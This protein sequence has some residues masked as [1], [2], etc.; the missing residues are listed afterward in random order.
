MQEL[1]LSICVVL[2]ESVEVTQRFHRALMASLEGFSE[3]EVLYYDNSPSDTLKHWFA[4]RLQPAGSYWHDPRNLG[5]SYGNNE[6]ILRARHERILLLNPDVFGLTPA[7]W[8]AIA[9]RPTQDQATFARLLNEDGSFQDCVGEPSSLARAFRTRPDYAAIRQPTVVGMGIM[10]FML[11]GRSVYAKVGLLDCSYPLYAEDMD[12]CYRA[13]EAG[14]KLVYDPG[15][16]LTH[17]GG[18][19]AKERWAR[20]ASLKRKYKAERI[21][22]DKHMHGFNWAA[23]RLLNALKIAIRARG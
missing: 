22:I 16:E 9:S 15:I 5:F 3:Y 19:S 13:S 23:M 1:N 7:I 11:T 18:A 21:F 4:T 20:A 17:L 12:W 10:A 8:S 2:Y 6:L 14:V